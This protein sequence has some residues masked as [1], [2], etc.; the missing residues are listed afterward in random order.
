MSAALG[1]AFE[2]DPIVEWSIATCVDPTTT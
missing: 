1:A 2:E